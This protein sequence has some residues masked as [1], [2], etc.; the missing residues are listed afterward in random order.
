MVSECRMQKSVSE[1]LQPSL[2]M[3]PLVH[4]LFTRAKY[5]TVA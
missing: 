2:S 3:P 5:T 1:R 4:P